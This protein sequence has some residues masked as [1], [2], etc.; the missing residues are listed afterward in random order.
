MDT[1]I[2]TAQIKTAANT[3]GQA[4]VCNTTDHRCRY[5]IKLV[6]NATTAAD[7]TNYVSLRGYK[8]TGTGTPVCAARDT[9]VDALTAYTPE[10][11]A[12]TATGKS[13]ELAPGEV[14]HFDA[15]HP[16][17]GAA[18]DCEIVVTL[19]PMGTVLA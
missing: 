10:T 4:T 3:D 18:I 19:T 11:L 5:A 1:V 2:L 15:T 17:T 7:G 9:S 16:G 6:P 14:I 13:A 12:V 8:G